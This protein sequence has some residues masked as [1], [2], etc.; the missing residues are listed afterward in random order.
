MNLNSHL[1]NKPFPWYE[2]ILA[3]INR[4]TLYTSHR[5]RQTHY[6]E[7]HLIKLFQPSANKNFI[8]DLIHL[9]VC[10]FLHPYQLTYNNLR[11]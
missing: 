6:Q 5:I 8:L 4:T 7:L 1:I 2:A 10:F 11:V 3:S 9:L